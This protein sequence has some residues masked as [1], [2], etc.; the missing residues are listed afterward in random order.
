MRHVLVGVDFSEPSRRAMEM[1]RSLR[2]KMH[3]AVTVVHVLEVPTDVS[4]G[5]IG[6]LLGAPAP[7]ELSADSPELT[8]V[9]D[10]LSAL[11][12]DAFGPDSQAIAI[13]VVAG[14][15]VDR[16]L[17]LAREEKADCIA[18]GTTGHSRMERALLGSVAERLVRASEVP[19]LTVH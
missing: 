12:R 14:R 4:M 6:R 3:A 17:D 15:P 8:Q 5:V 9:R 19:V 11:V 18:V 10:N 16:L 1:A 7:P 13:K 2:A